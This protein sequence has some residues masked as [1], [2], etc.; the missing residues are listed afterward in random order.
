M[1]MSMFAEYLLKKHNNN[2]SLVKKIVRNSAILANEEGDSESF[3]MEMEC[4]QAL[5]A[6]EAQSN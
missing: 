6:I 1:D 3:Q 2:M 4:F 5:E